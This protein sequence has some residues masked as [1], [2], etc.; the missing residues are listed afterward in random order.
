[1]KSIFPLSVKEIQGMEVPVVEFSS[2]GY[3]NGKVLG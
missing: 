2:D 1:M 3:K